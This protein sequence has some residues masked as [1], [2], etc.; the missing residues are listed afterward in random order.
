M[1]PLML[2]TGWREPPSGWCREHH[3]PPAWNLRDKTAQWPAPAG[4]MGATR[5]FPEPSQAVGGSR[6]PHSGPMMAGEASVTKG[7]GNICSHK[8]RRVWTNYQHTF[9]ILGAA[10]WL[11]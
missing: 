10:R 1:A 5:W 3:V 11:P 6:E 8:F 7:C 4:I 2:K 9:G